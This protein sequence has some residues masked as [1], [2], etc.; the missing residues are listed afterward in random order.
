MNQ[1]ANKE[2]Y[3]A[4]LVQNVSKITNYLTDGLMSKGRYHLCKEGK[5]ERGQKESQG[6]LY[7]HLQHVRIDTEISTPP[8]PELHAL[9]SI[10]KSKY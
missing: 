2:L 5:V 4:S 7:V 10:L 8:I 9:K 1:K 3:F 6:A